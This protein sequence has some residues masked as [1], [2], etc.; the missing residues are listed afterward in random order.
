MAILKE[1]RIHIPHSNRSFVK[2]EQSGPCPS[3]SF[4]E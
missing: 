3:L 2:A 4:N 1:I